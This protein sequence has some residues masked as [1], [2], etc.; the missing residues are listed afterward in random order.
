MSWA[1]GHIARLR[2][3]ETVQFRPRGSSMRGRVESGQL[4]TVEPVSPETALAVGDVVLC[5]VRGS[6]YLHL[7]KAFGDGGSSVQIGNNRGHVNGW[8]P[9][10]KVYG[11]LVRVEP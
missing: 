9:R 8:T 11:K 3:G 4:V 1:T 6:D 2:N 10:T 5:S 7:I